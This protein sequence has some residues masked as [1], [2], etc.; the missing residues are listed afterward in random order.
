VGSASETSQIPEARGLSVHGASAGFVVAYASVRLVLVV[1][2]ERAR[3]HVPQRLYGHVESFLGPAHGFAGCVLALAAEPT[4]ELHRRAA[5]ALRETA[6]TEDG[7]AN[8]PP[9]A[10]AGLVGEDGGIRVQ[11]CHGAPGWSPRSRASRPGTTRTSGCSWP[12][13]S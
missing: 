4:E 13:A 5:A 9:R 3:R 6:V 2:Y 11:W 12:A 10:S 7:L 1:L 8:W